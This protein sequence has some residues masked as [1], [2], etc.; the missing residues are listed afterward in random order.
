[1]NKLNVVKSNSRAGKT[2][3][4]VVIWLLF[5]ILPVFLFDD[6]ERVFRSAPVFYSTS[7]I[8]LIPFYY[9]N[10]NYLMPK[11][12]LQQRV[13]VY[14]IILAFG[15]I[16]YEYVPRIITSLF[17]YAGFT[18]LFSDLHPGRQAKVQ[19]AT[20]V[21]FLIVLVVGIIS[22]LYKVQR[23]KN[24][25]EAANT[26]AELSLLKSQVNPHFLFNTLNSI[27]YMSLK[28]MDEAPKAIITLSD[29]MRYLLTEAT[30]DFVTLEQ[31]IDYINKY[32]G[33]QKLRISKSTTI[34][35]SLNGNVENIQIAPLL[36]IPFIEN[37]FKYGVSSNTDSLIKIQID[38]EEKKLMLYVENSII[39]REEETEGTSLGIKNISKRLELLYP[40]NHKLTIDND[41]NI[42]HVNLQIGF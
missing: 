2:L 24:D 9:F 30:V 13:L 38:V 15:V 1:M 14:I 29:M 39:A 26:K 21:F 33:F 3:L 16:V 22:N 28:K 7:I 37:A 11:F 12:L 41:G 34:D 17:Q 18:E 19:M 8:L 36:L 25:L 4:H 23:R 31:E 35:Y 40:D 6:Y 5:I 32:I 10:H 20:L 27:Y 42:Y